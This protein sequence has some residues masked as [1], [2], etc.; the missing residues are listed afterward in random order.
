M[1]HTMRSVPRHTRITTPTILHTTAVRAVHSVWVPAGTSVRKRKY[2]T[3]H[4]G[5]QG[6]IACYTNINAST[7][8]G[9]EYAI[10]YWFVYRCELTYKSTGRCIIPVCTK[11]SIICPISTLVYE[12][13]WTIWNYVHSRRRIDSKHNTFEKRALVT[14]DQFGSINE[15]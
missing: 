4:G 12:Q 3:E 14:T 2:C 15:R 8:V 5:K 11:N 13:T 6:V 1:C 9:F 10:N 7:W